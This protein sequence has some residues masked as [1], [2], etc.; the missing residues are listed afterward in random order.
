M[1]PFPSV[2]SGAFH[3]NKEILQNK[4]KEVKDNNL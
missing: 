3:V 1:S 4:F 2:Y